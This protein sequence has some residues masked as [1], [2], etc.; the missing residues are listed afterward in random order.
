MT[1]SVAESNIPAPPPYHNSYHA[2][3]CSIGCL[4]KLSQCSALYARQ[5]LKIPLQQEETHSH[6]H[7]C[8]PPSQGT[9]PHTMVYAVIGVCNRI[10]IPYDLVD[11]PTEVVG[12]AGSPPAEDGCVQTLSSVT[13][14]QL[15][16]VCNGVN[17]SCRQLVL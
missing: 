7:Q 3:Y 10:S 8:P 17:I 6:A 4:P 15:S 16:K 5:F 9:C 2:S 1:T 14:D 13:V 12:L 11:E